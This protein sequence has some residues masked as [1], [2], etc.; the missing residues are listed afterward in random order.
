MYCIPYIIQVIV[1]M[2]LVKIQAKPL[3]EG[4]VHI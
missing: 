3:E 4:L 2:I 1:K